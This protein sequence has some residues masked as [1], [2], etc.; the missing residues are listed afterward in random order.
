MGYSTLEMD[1][2][3]FLER[4]FPKTAAQAAKVFW[5]GVDRHTNLLL[6]SKQPVP[7]ATNTIPEMF[8]ARTDASEFF[9]LW[10]RAISHRSQTRLLERKPKV[11]VKKVL[12]EQIKKLQAQGKLVRY[13]RRIV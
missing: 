11:K 13:A 12:T 3:N 9:Q 7:F 1:V 6:T 5:E 8:P 2:G 10:L 4:V